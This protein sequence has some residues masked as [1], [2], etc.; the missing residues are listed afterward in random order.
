MA[1]VVMMKLKKHFPPNV[2]GETCSFSPKTAEHI[3]NHNGGEE[4]ARF[5]DTTHRFDQKTG[6]AVK[7]EKDDEGSETKKPKA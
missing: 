2:A 7:I 4:L 6:K 5:D 1:D 3:K